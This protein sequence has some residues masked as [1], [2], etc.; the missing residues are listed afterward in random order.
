MLRNLRPSCNPHILLRINILYNLFQRLE[1]TW[2]ANAAAVKPNGHHFR[3]AFTAFFVQGIK[4]SFD[5]VV[6]IGGR[7]EAGWDVEFV[8]IAI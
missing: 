4:S 5:V 3:C 1:T 2:F 6:K 8:V 7:A